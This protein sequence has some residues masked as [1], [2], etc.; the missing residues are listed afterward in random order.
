MRIHVDAEP[1]FAGAE[2]LYPASHWL[3]STVAVSHRVPSTPLAID[4]IPFGHV[5]MLA[6]QV[7]AYTFAFP[8]QAPLF[9]QTLTGPVL[10]HVSLVHV[11]HFI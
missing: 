3:Q 6:V 7:G 8:T 11:L 1:N 2:S 9:V 10:S 5:Q 4:A